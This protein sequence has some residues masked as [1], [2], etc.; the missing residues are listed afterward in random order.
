MIFK[1]RLRRG[2][3]AVV[4]AATAMA[5]AG[6]G[7]AHAWTNYYCGVGI[8][9]HSWCGDGTNHTYDSNR[10]YGSS[11]VYFCERLVWAD[12]GG[13]ETSAGYSCGWGS[14]YRYYGSNPQWLYEAEA[15]HT[16]NGQRHTVN[17]TAVA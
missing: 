2:S 3:V 16:F 10:A 17:G 11:S 5:I 13:W 9:G 8:I 15:T 4:A 14:I 7:E 12:T 1:N 6:T